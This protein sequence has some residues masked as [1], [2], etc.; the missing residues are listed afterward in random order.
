MTTRATAGPKNAE[1][2][3]KRRNKLVADQ[4][5]ASGLIG[6]RKD[7]RFSVWASS[8]LVAAAKK[9]AG[10]NSNTE[11]LELALSH[12]ALEDDFGTRLVHRKGSL[13][14]TLDISI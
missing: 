4:A 6:D 11:L 9:R 14:K 3:A 1:A 10:V 12:L 2:M 8:K 13:P 5:K 7:E